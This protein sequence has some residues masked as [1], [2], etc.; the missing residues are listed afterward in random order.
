[1]SHPDL[2]ILRHGQTVWNLAGRMQG[3]MDSPLT[4]LGEAQARQMNSMLKAADLPGDVTY[5]ASPQG[6]CRATAEL[7]LAAIA[8]AMPPASAVRIVV[9]SS[10]SFS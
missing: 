2:W 9:P 5:H 10:F 8:R 7:A 4:R 6:R 3:R 1:M